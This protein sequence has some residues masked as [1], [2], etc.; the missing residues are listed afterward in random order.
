[1][2]IFITEALAQTPAA[3]GAAQGQGGGGSSLLTGFLVP[4]LAMI[5]IF[6]FILIRPQQKKEKER[7]KLLESIQK[8]DKVVTVGG[9][10]GVVMS[11]KPEEGKVTLK[12]ADNTKVEFA[13]SSIQTKLP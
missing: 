4:M 2:F 6:Y 13:K 12:I 7:K 3:T 10:Y 9:I 8:G 5:V 11:V 1:M